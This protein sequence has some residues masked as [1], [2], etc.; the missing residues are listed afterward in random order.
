MVQ[1]DLPIG[2]WLLLT[3]SRFTACINI[4]S[5]YRKIRLP[6]SKS[7]RSFLLYRSC[8]LVLP[9]V[10]QNLTLTL[11]LGIL[12]PTIHEYHIQLG[13]LLMRSSV[14][15]F[16]RLFTDSLKHLQWPYFV[17]LCQGQ[18]LTTI[19]RYSLVIMTF[20]ICFIRY[21]TISWL[22][23][24][25]SDWFKHGFQGFYKGRGFPVTMDE[26]FVQQTRDMPIAMY[27]AQVNVWMDAINDPKQDDTVLS[28]Q[29]QADIFR[30]AASSSLPDYASIKH[31]VFSMQRCLRN[32]EIPLGGKVAPSCV[33]TDPASANYNSVSKCSCREVFLL[34]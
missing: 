7:D 18:L 34:P 3:S 1:N 28:L 23:D 26:I 12:A 33:V 27:L 14:Y 2:S 6:S 19:P 10:T 8:S 17:S 32:G 24:P 9:L 5:L 15:C 11:L 4:S 16:R 29:Q 13:Q 30:Q 22:V 20:Q 31:V 25:L 21:M